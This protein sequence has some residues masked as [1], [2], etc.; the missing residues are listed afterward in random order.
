VFAEDA[1]VEAK[2][3]FAMQSIVAAAR[4]AQQRWSRLTVRER[5]VSVRRLRK[6]IAS[7]AEA[8]ALTVPLDLPGSLHRS[9]ADTLVTEVLP[10]L[11]AC[12][13][14]E[15]EAEFILA[16]R[17]EG[18]TS[19]PVWLHG[20]SVE[21]R[22]DPMGVVLVIGPGNYPLLLPGVQVLQALVAG[23]AVLWKPAPGGA[24]PAY[25]L[26]RMLV[27]CGLDQALVTVIGTEAGRA[28]AAIR[29][30][31]DKV[32][33]T[34]S[35]TTGRAVMHELAE[36]LTPAVMELSGCDAVF[37]LDDAVA[38]KKGLDRVVDALTFALRLNGSATCMAPRRL[39]VT[40]AVSNK[41][42]GPLAASLGELARV[43]VPAQ[44][45]GLLS[46]LI[47]EATLYGAKVVLNGLHPE[48]EGRGVGATLLTGV[49]PEM[50][51]AQTD[52]FA[53]VLS[54]LRVE[55]DEGA[56]VTHN[57]C[58]YA[59]TAAV[60]GPVKEAERLAARL[61]AGTVL[62]NDIVV[63]TADPRA[64]FGGR[65]QSGYGA[66]RGREG[67]LAMTAAKT[68]LRQRSRSRRAFQMTGTAHIRFFASLA[69]ALHAG[70]WRLRLEGAR[71]L[72]H[73]ARQIK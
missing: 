72:I 40:D 4:E 35:A 43:P 61:Q 9:P 27:A 51:I 32:V 26:Q 49:T 55:S 52:I 66:T 24:N 38:N 58:P 1:R 19:R 23:N 41:L 36:T 12:R 11:E 31:I 65:K 56:I 15:R 28:T 39:F 45:R 7:G 3:Q 10:L 68:I 42:V 8:L 62:I 25:A 17:F 29:T 5:L 60:F 48:G 67:L 64:S 22:R 71:K 18:T 14:L 37:V 50:R 59:L 30:G 47:D 6:E 13:F 44:A 33:L 20:V 54:L 57:A 63:A 21:T 2:D 34:G 70:S 16:S 69:Q 46:E 53:P 73:A